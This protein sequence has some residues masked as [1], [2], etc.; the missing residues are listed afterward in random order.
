MAQ[1][2]EAAGV[3]FHS[4]ILEPEQPKY[5]KMTSAELWVKAIATP[6]IYLV[7][8]LD[9]IQQFSEPC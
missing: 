5:A 1:M 4:K 6:L 7:D 3:V 2:A 8:C 9:I